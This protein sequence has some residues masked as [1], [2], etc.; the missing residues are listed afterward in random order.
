[1]RNFRSCFILCKT[2]SLYSK[3]DS[4]VKKHKGTDPEVKEI[5][6]CEK[7]KK[8]CCM[9]CKKLTY[10]RFTLNRKSV[11]LNL[12]CGKQIITKPVQKEHAI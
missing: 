10:G 8:K 6:S 7:N 9:R 1:M 12:I 3:R 11:C 4:K 2:F 5:V